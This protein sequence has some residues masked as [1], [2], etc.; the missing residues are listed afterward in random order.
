MCGRIVR[1][2]RVDQIAKRFEVP[3]GEFSETLAPSVNIPPSSPSPNVVVDEGSRRLQ[4]MTWGL[5][6]RSAQKR[7]G[8]HIANIRTDTLAKG[9]FRGLLM[10]NRCLVPADGFYE[11]QTTPDGKRPVFFSLKDDGVF[12]FAALYAEDE[13]EVGVPAPPTFSIFTTEPNPLVADY[14]D[15]MPVILRREDEAAWLDPSNK[16]AEDLLALLRSYPAREMK[17]HYVSPAI[18]SPKNDSPE[19]LKPVDWKEQPKLF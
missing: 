3:Y 18:N 6:P 10:K 9:S 11:W 5:R 13:S 2:V 14:H 19:L 15:R 17:S 4:L 12:A 16:N 1:R 7:A 8:N